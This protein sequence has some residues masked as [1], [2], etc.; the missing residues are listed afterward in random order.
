MKRSIE[1]LISYL[2]E[3]EL[4]PSYQ[5][6]KILGYL[7]ENQNHPT[8]NEIYESL[9]GEIPTLSKSTVYN[10]LNIFLRA[11]LVKQL[12]IEGAETRY[13]I[14]TRYHGHF[15]CEHCGKIFNFRINT[16]SYDT[17]DLKGFNIKD[18]NVHFTGTCPSCLK[19]KETRGR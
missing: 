18:R 12:A 15:K 8:A 13:D 4:R 17:S 6:L 1:E 11:R 5:R 3:R 16:E 10:T 7:L 9:H 19:G 2:K 14:I